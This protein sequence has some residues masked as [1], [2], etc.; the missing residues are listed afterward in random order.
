M[1]NSFKSYKLTYEFG[2]WVQRPETLSQVDVEEICQKSLEVQEQIANYPFDKVEVV[3]EKLRNIWK[4]PKSSYRVAAQQTLPS[5]TGF[6]DEMVQLGLEELAQMLD[7]ELLKVKLNT[8][9]R[10]IPRSLGYKY[11]AKANRLLQYKPLGTIFHVL[12]GNVFLV[13]P[14]S[15][16][17]GLITGNVSILKMSS[18]EN[19]FMPLFMKSVQ[20]VDTDKVVSSSVALLEFSSQNKSV[21]DTFKK[22]VDGI[23][24]WGGEEAVQAYRD[25]TPARTRVVVFGPKLSFA[26]VTAK[27]F[28]QAD[29][30]QVSLNLAKELAI[31]DQNACTAPQICY[32]Q[33]LQ[34]AQALVGALPEALSE[35][36]KKWPAGTLSADAAA[37]IRKWRGVAEMSEALGEGM[38]RDSGLTSLD[39]TVI[40]T[41]ELDLQPSPLH[42]TIRIVPFENEPMIENVVKHYRGYL[43]TVGLVADPEEFL[44]LAQMFSK[45]GA[46]RIFPLGQMS[47]GD[48]DD[49]HDG[50]YDLPL[51]LELIAIRPPVENKSTKSFYDGW[52]FLTQSE[53]AKYQAQ[54]FRELI[55]IAK[56]SPYYAEHFKDVEFDSLAD[57]KNI[58]LLKREDW[59]ANMLP[60]S[61]NL[62]TRNS[63]GGYVTRSGGST[64]IPKFSYFDKSD[65]DAMA[66]TAVRM[67]RHCGFTSSDRLANFMMAGD[68]YGS[69][70]SFNHINYLLGIE[71]FCF[72]GS[73]EPITFLEIAK[74]FKINAVQGVVP[75]LMKILRGAHAL[76]PQFQIEK[77]MYAGQ[78]MSPAD[79]DWLKNT[80]GAKIITSIIG[81]TEANQIGYQCPHL[82]GDYHHLAEDYNYFEI[83]DEQNNPIS[84]ESLGRLLVT[85]LH[86]TN[87]PVIRYMIGDAARFVHKPCLCGSLDRVI[88]YKG[89]WDDIISLGLMNIKLSDI[90]KALESLPISEMQFVARYNNE[91]DEI[92]LKI[93]SDEANKEQLKEQMKQQLFQNIHEFEEFYHK[94]FFVLTIDVYPIGTIPR[95]P[96]TGKIKSIIEERNNNA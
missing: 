96:R 4:D 72:G 8:E 40:L 41:K 44:K 52:D 51:F 39:W 3:L 7:S 67:F 81:T 14:G 55:K 66:I 2:H 19:F 22:N 20:E 75:T 73:I 53:K 1:I 58:P 37:E 43:Q 49:P 9:L 32:V 36:Q 64:G 85:G 70:I 82:K 48:I 27:G 71:S 61:Q 34:N 25:Q 91:K 15:F 74:Q 38:L 45:Y 62:Q 92:Y 35:Y 95:N 68:L 83:I 79:R 59:E 16:I 26:L 87:F 93:E 6:S 50:Q 88:E 23:V 80:M 94:K 84:D 29:I 28:E 76:D 10:G 69:F 47:G 21:I 13:G 63:E 5:Y 78:S 90:K 11:D 77:V 86:K 42:R 18:Q 56:K 30:K 54:K 65:W 89:R 24:I 31:W 46:Q 33:G 57:L 12:S 60:A 17:Q